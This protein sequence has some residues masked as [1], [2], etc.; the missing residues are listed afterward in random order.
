[1]STGMSSGGSSNLRSTA[2]KHLRRTNPTPPCF[3]TSGCWTSLRTF[4]SGGKRFEDSFCR[5]RT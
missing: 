4:R 2:L 1:L 3:C 5:L